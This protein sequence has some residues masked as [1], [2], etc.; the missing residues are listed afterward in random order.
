MKKNQTVEAFKSNGNS[1]NSNS[2]KNKFTMKKLL[3]IFTFLLA[4]TSIVICQGFWEIINTPPNAGVNS[5][6]VS[7]NEDIFLGVG[8]SS[9]GGVL[10][11]LNNGNIWDTSLYLSNKVIGQIYVDNNDNIFAA[12]DGL[13]YSDDNGD[14]WELLYTSH[15]FGI[16]SIKKTSNGST[17]FGMWG[18]IYKYDSI[19]SSWLEVLSLEN[20]EIVNSIIENINSG[21]LYAGTTNFIRGGGVYRS[22]DGGSNWEHIGLTD[23]YISSL[24]MNS[25][26]DLFAGARGHYSL[27]IYGAGVFKLANGQTEWEHLIDWELVTSMVIN[28]EDVIYI[29]CSALDY[30]GGVRRSKDNGQT[31]EDISLESMHGRDIEGLALGSEEHLYALEYYSSTPLYKSVNSTITSLPDNR[32]DEG[33]L[34][35]NY[36]NPFTEETTLHFKLPLTNVTEAKITIYNSQGI[37]IQDIILPTYCENEQSIKWNPKELPAGMYYYKIIAGSSQVIKKMV[38]HK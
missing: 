24:A 11:S 23:H 16:T 26:G 1:I 19:D 38:L 9:G 21:T 35:Y 6:D 34:T 18:G 30:S 33:I 25:S 3:L 37:I 10:R 17:F 12:S 36:P 27:Y 28:S 4:S 29:G 8:L 7:S 20:T 22:I 31:W 2:Y 32:I 14:N 5:I 15:V 13:Y